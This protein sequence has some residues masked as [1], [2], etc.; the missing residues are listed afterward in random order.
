MIKCLKFLLFL[1]LFSFIAS[2]TL[3]QDRPRGP[4]KLEPKK[5]KPQVIVPYSKETLKEP[6]KFGKNMMSVKHK[7]IT[8][9]P[10][11]SLLKLSEHHIPPVISKEYYFSEERKKWLERFN[12]D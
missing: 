8:C 12:N 2:T 5:D 7:P 4:L 1:G 3:A 10:K 6:P 11:E 9:G